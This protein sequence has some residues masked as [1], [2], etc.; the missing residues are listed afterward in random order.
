[1]RSMTSSC[2]T[3]ANASVIDSYVTVSILVDST[4]RFAAVLGVPHCLDGSDESPHRS[5]TSGNLPRWSIASDLA[6]VYCSGV[7][8]SSTG[9]NSALSIPH[10][11]PKRQHWRGIVIAAFLLIILSVFVLF[12]VYFICHRVIR[13][14]VPLMGSERKNYATILNSRTS[15]EAASLPS[16][17]R[18]FPF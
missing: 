12:V 5:C 10:S 9:G 17:A 7:M 11:P 6:R 18:L 1:M 8:S 13:S 16:M 15:T 14:P 3:I 2:A 4:D